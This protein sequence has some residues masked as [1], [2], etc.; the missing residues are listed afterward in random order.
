MSFSDDTNHP[1]SE[2]D[3][4]LALLEQELFSLRPTA[5][6]PLLVK[7]ITRAMDGKGTRAGRPTTTRA[8]MNTVVEKTLPFSQ[9]RVPLWRKVAPWAAAAAVTAAGTH[10]WPQ[11][12]STNTIGDNS[13]AEESIH[14]R[15]QKVRA[16]RQV[17]DIR[18]EGISLDPRYGAVRSI[19]MEFNNNLQMQ[20]AS[21][22]RLDYQYPSVERVVI[23]MQFH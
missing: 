15:L 19:R 7:Q 2:Q 20:E 14:S 13:L 11:N 3:S 17:Q 8:E 10:F 18:E 12:A 16:K 5:V 1:F 4:D 23:P 6:N 22:G 9:P 21:G